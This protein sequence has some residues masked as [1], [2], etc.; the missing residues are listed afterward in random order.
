MVRPP[1]GPTRFGRGTSGRL[2]SRRSSRAR[3]GAATLGLV[4]LLP[5]RAIA[6]DIKLWPLF[7]YASEGPGDEVRWTA[8]G[9]LLEFTRTADSRDLRI[10][11]LLWLH[12]RRGPAHD[13]RAEILFPLAATRWQEDYQSFRFL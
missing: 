12:Q 6:L 13:D 11:P 9:P 4:L 10:R 3:L 2:T 1:A 7:R 8:F 5:A